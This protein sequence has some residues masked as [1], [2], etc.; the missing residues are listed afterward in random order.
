MHHIP[1]HRP[2]TGSVATIKAPILSRCLCSFADVKVIATSSSRYFVTE[3]QLPPEAR[4]LLG[5]RS[6]LSLA[7]SGFG[8]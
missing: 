5:V 2:Q 8:W 7:L 3:E 6:C 1:H 4:P